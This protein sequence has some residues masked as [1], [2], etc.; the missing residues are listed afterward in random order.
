MLDRLRVGRRGLN[1]GFR[2]LYHADVESL[3]EFVAPFVSAADA[4]N[5]KENKGLYAI[6]SCLER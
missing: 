5:G 4:V 2:S 3:D 1:T 6:R